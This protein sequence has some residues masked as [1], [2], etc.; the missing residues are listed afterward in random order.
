MCVPRE[1]TFPWKQF[2]G[3]NIDLSIRLFLDTVPLLPKCFQNTI[4]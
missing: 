1:K 4:L 3:W 2:H